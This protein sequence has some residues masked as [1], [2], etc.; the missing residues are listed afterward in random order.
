MNFALESA[1]T[2]FEGTADA[3]C[4]GRSWRGE[5]AMDEIPDGWLVGHLEPKLPP[6]GITFYGG[7]LVEVVGYED[8]SFHVFFVRR[9]G[10]DFKVM[11]PTTPHA[12]PIDRICIS[13]IC[14]DDEPYR[15][16]LH[17]TINWYRDSVSD[18]YL[19]VSKFSAIDFHMAR[20]RNIGL[21]RATCE[22]VFMLDVDVRLTKAEIDSVIKK[23]RTVPN[24]GVLN[25]KNSPSH[26]N[27]LYFGRRDVLV[28]NGY[29]ERFRHFWCEDTEYLMNF[30]RTGVI[31]IVVYEPFLRIDH[32]RAKTSA[33]A[34][35]N[36]DL[37][38]KIIHAGRRECS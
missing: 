13:L 5:V 1:K 26:G 11:P 8:G 19:S 27:G 7:R 3:Y 6:D 24:H 20:A 14:T 9:R 12:D 32:S 31:P 18:I 38:K 21:Q 28:N 2:K 33:Y 22:Y 4:T 36:V 35:T 23:L 15:T 37:M 29:D 16:L 30:S 10:E 17:D 34:N 25:L